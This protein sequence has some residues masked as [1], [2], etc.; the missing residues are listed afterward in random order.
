M[1]GNG[2]GERRNREHKLASVNAVPADRGPIPF[3]G[4]TRD[5][6]YAQDRREA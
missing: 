2:L 1:R 5:S 3:A 6:S 4:P